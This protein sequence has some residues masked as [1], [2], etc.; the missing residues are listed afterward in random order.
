MVR[1][2][3]LTDEER[4]A[5]RVLSR[6]GLSTRQI[7]DAVQR[8]VG[9]CHKVL[10]TPEKPKRP[11]RRGSPAK[12]TERDRRHIIRCVSSEG[13]GAQRVKDK[14]KLPY[15]K[16]TIQ[17]VIAGCTWLKFKKLRAAPALKPHHKK[18]RM[19]WAAQMVH[20]E[21]VEWC[22]IVFS[23]EKKWNLDGPDGMRYR[24]VDT[25]TTEPVMMRRHSGGGSVMVWGGFCGGKK[26]EIKFL[27]GK[28]ASTDYVRTLETHLRPF[29]DT[30]TQVFQ[31]DNASIHVSKHTLG[32][33]SRHGIDLLDWPALSPDLNPI[34]NVWGSM[35]R[36]VYE[37]GKQYESIAALKR[38]VKQAWDEIPTQELENL[39][40]SMRKR[41]VSVLERQ[42]AYISY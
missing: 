31:Q 29:I 4:H 24:W 17:R 16:R 11:S 2:L 6:G 21:D 1:G 34:E 38:A 10:S 3:E 23:D 36:R 19:A 20:L 5:I 41:C 42:G 9:V 7:A 15:S 35:T 14:L 18:Q 26:T 12:V 33:F 25:R 32:W 28:Q 8:S 30:E 40:L 13:I 22:S 39:V 37:G 27:E